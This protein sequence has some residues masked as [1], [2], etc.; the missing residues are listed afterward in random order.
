MLAA[1]AVRARFTT[2]V[3]IVARGESGQSANLFEARIST[4]AVQFGI[5]ETG[6]IKTNQSVANTNTPSGA[7][8]RAL[9]IF[10]VAGAS[11]GFIPVYAA[12]W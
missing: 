11:L 4:D 12:Q 8:A 2:W 10:D 7:T 6:R 5:G 3:P 1:L 9:E